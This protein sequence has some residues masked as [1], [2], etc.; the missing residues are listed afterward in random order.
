MLSS[1]S[2]SSSSTG[3]PDPFIIFA[4]LHFISSDWSIRSAL[5]DWQTLVISFSKSCGVKS[6]RFIK[7]I[8]IGMSSDGWKIAVQIWSSGSRLWVISKYISLI[9]LVI[10]LLISIKEAS[11]KLRLSAILIFLVTIENLSLYDIVVLKRDDFPASF[12]NESY[13]TFCFLA[14][15]LPPPFCSL[16]KKHFLYF[17]SFKSSEEL[18]TY[19]KNYF[20]L[21]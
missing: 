17:L 9:N 4:I 12:S 14:R 6:S 5:F 10:F 3:K 16:K 13:L 1:S 19:H 8:D 18:M 15:F 21:F 11:F 20:R 7:P 2:S